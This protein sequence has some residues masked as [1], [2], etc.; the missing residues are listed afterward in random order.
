ML[1]YCSFS[2]RG[3]ITL[4]I[5]YSDRGQLDAAL[6][7]LQTASSLNPRNAGVQYYL[8]NVFL[9]K[10]LIDPAIEHFKAAAALN[11]SQKVFLDALA[12]AYEQKRSAPH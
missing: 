12:E 2:L 8:G 1:R 4:G 10:G 9:K 5:V 6:I 3:N 11:P 7:H